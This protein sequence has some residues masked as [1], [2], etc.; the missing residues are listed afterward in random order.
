MSRDYKREAL[1][2]E[3]EIAHRNAS[4]AD[5]AGRYG[6]ASWWEERERE[7]REELLK[8]DETAQNPS[9]KREEGSDG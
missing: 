7:L 9:E 2:S 6:E 3:I 4:G 1:R 5:T 8:C